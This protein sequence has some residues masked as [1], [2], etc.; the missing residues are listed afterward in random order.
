MS[1]H[2]FLKFFYDIDKTKR[3]PGYWK[4][5]VSYLENE[6]YKK[7]IIDIIHSISISSSPTAAW[8]LIKRK[9]KDYSINF[10]IYEQK[11]I[12][13]EIKSIE[14]Q[15]SK[16]ERR[17]RTPEKRTHKLDCIFPE[18]KRTLKKS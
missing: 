17:K 11:S 1:D 9:V 4:L 12:K 15:R 2:R 6:N 18:R 8:E 13:A 7:G 10:A 16:I 5:N 3:G 14:H